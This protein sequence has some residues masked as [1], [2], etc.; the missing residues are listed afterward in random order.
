MFRNQKVGQK[1]GIELPDQKRF[2][3]DIS[4]KICSNNNLFIF[5]GSYKYVTSKTIPIIFQ[6]SR[7]FKSGNFSRSTEA[8]YIRNEI[9]ILCLK[10][11]S[12]A[13]VLTKDRAIHGLNIKNIFKV[14]LSTKLCL[15]HDKVWYISFCLI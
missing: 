1:Y 7:N 6:F 8:L 2:L 5:T 11:C 3:E 13:N 4:Q 12:C 14:Y 15:L 10:L 9:P